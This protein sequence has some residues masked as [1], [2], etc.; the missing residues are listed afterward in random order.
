[1]IRPATRAD[2]AGIGA[3]WN[4]VIRDTT[5]TFNPDEKPQE[6]IAALVAG[7]DP[8]FVWDESGG[9]GGDGGADG[10]GRILGFARHFQFRGGAGYRHT[11]EHTVLLHPD[12]QGRGIGRALMGAV[13]EDAR[14]A[15]HRSLFAGVSAENPAGVAFHAALGFATV[16][17]LPGVGFKFGRWIDLVLMQKRL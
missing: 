15:G 12:G 8:C 7:P 6:E 10:G 1:M 17:V 9:G 14:A 3:I 11:R 5:I 13:I 2:A 16:A 4:P